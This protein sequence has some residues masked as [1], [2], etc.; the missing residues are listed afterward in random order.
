MLS[1]EISTQSQVKP[2][3]SPRRR[4]QEKERLM[5]LIITLSTEKSLVQKWLMEKCL[6]LLVLMIGSMG[7]DMSHYD[8]IA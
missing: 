7:L 4:E 8:L 3:S 6:K 1:G 2:S 5:A